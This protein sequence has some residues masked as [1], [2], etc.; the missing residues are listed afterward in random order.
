MPS[1]EQRNLLHAIYPSGG[2]LSN[3]PSAGRSRESP[4]MPCFKA[5]ES[6][7]FSFNT[8]GRRSTGSSII[9]D[10]VYCTMALLLRGLSCIELLSEPDECSESWAATE[11]PTTS[12]PVAE[13]L[14]DCQVTT[15]FWMLSKRR[16]MK[17]GLAIQVIS[18]II[19]PTR[20][21][22]SA[23]PRST[24]FRSCVI[25]H[26]TCYRVQSGLVFPMWYA[27]CV[28]MHE[29]MCFRALIW[30]NLV[31]RIRILNH[32]WSKWGQLFVGI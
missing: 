5:I 18:N 15:I 29:M 19:F 9:T 2:L 20:I 27:S 14:D 6:K 26:Q 10:G 28:V 1:A 11:G 8:E 7:S 32:F 22:V 17:S 12:D 16:L 31:A 25:G 21:R 30:T 23:E 24:V 3:C 13:A 4:R